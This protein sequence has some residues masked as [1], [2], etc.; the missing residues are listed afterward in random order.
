MLFKNYSVSVHS[1]IN[2]KINQLPGAIQGS[3]KPS[4]GKKPIRYA[5][6]TLSSG[7][8][9]FVAKVSSRH[10]LKCLTVPL[11]TISRTNRFIHQ[12]TLRGIK[13]RFI[14]SYRCLIQKLR[15]SELCQ[16]T[17]NRNN[18]KDQE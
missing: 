14:S 15:C 11:L 1:N 12:N 16:P 13:Q 9:G 5:R 18:Q 17:A 6:S 3:K 2:L 8:I 10:Q 7:N 4:L